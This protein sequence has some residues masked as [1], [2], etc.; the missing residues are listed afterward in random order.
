[1]RV[2]H[3]FEISLLCVV[4]LSFKKNTDWLRWH[5]SI[6]L[7]SS[8]QCQQDAVWA[9]SSFSCWAPRCY[10]WGLTL[11]R[12][13]CVVCW[14]GLGEVC[15]RSKVRRQRKLQKSRSLQNQLC[16][17]FIQLNFINCR[18]ETK[19]SIWS[20]HHLLSEENK[21]LQILCE[22]WWPCYVIL[23]KIFSK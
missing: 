13:L 22:M 12:Q 21:E 3:W 7:N 11:L 17:V 4:C 6:F 15:T 18:D 9:H 2:L 5:F 19:Y 10:L 16:I 20:V 23:C 1:M 14:F 8:W